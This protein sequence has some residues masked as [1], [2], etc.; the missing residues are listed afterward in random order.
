MN[1]KTDL[2]P[3]T[4]ILLIIR[5]G[6]DNTFEI[7]KL[8]EFSPKHGGRFE[9]LKQEFAPLHSPGL[10]FCVSLGGRFEQKV[11]EVFWTITLFFWLCS[12]IYS[13][14]GVF[15]TWLV[16]PLQF[17][18]HDFDWFVVRSNSTESGYFERLSNTRLSRHHFIV[19]LN[20]WQT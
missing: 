8:M 9:K 16:V 13:M 20:Q 6:L 19:A 7:S 15:W 18:H 5:D 11:S 1:R 17:F 14:Y 12:L 2:V 4:Y 3:P 10:M